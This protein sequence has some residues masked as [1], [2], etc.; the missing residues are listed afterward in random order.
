M[1]QQ[2]CGSNGLEMLHIPFRLYFL[3]V[4]LLYFAGCAPY[5]V[6]VSDVQQPPLPTDLIEIYSVRVEKQDNGVQV[7]IT[8][9]QP[10]SYSI[11]NH[12]NPPHITV[13]LQQARFVDLPTALTVG[14]GGVRALHLMRA[15]GTEAAARLEILLTE[16]ASYSYSVAKEQER[17]FVR[18][19]PAP[20]SPPLALLPQ[21]PSSL[22]PP[23]S[24]ITPSIAPPT[25]PPSSHDYRIGARDVLAITVYDEPDLTTKLR[26]T[27]SGFIYFPLVGSV[28]VQ[29]LTPTEVGKRLEEL[30][31]Q[32]YLLN[33]QVFVDVAEYESQKVFILGAI[34][35]PINF[36]LRGRT[37]LLELLAQLGGKLSGEEGGR[38]SSL[39]VFR[40]L[41]SGED[42]EK[43]ASKEV[44][45]IRV[46]LDRL[47]RQGDMS[48]NLVLQ[49]HDV[50]YVPE[51]DAVFVF[52]QVGKPGPIILPEGGMTLVE[53]ISKAGG[54]T[55]IAAPGRTRVFRMVDGKDQAIRVNVADII[56]HGN[57]SQDIALKA[58]DIVVIPESWF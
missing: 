8:G 54:L 45:A 18:I 49:A 15:P 38:S 25:L 11:D 50:I 42:Q 44:K 52:G 27:E 19:H 41:T 13:D 40:Q 9:S 3:L 5:T 7:V 28:E 31:G 22:P 21:P 46:D 29:G 56:K 1:A 47:L 34:E 39:V 6:D 51:P 12:G 26:V 32:G 30:L 35:K 23:T 53:A 58:N 4:P 24:P 43:P 33:P 48:L 37:T 55:S 36:T 14:E 2:E 20:R 57:R 10:L 17:L 16:Q